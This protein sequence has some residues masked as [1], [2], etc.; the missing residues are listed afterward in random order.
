MAENALGWWRMYKSNCQNVVVLY[1]SDMCQFGRAYTI[2]LLKVSSY[3]MGMSSFLSLAPIVSRR[4][5][6]ASKCD[7]FYWSSVWCRVAAW[8]SLHYHGLAKCYLQQDRSL[9]VV[10]TPRM[11]RTV[12]S[13]SSHP[14]LLNPSWWIDHFQFDSVCSSHMIYTLL[15]SYNLLWFRHITLIALSQLSL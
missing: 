10:R 14:H 11:N 7:I 6:D 8:K 12:I 13:Q 15:R 5:Q 9:D 1:L 3:I 2:C 4:C